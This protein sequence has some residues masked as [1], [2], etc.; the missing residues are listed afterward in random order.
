[1]L[2]RLHVAGILEPLCTSGSRVWLIQRCKAVVSR[3]ISNGTYGTAHACSTISS[4]EC[5]TL[6]VRVPFRRNS[7]IAA[8]ITRKRK[9]GMTSINKAIYF[10][11]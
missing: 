6:S 9:G 4:V 10:Q 7:P 11:Y 8:V 3:G 1:M 2:N 5:R